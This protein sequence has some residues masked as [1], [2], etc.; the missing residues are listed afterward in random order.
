MDT[1]FTNVTIDNLE[2]DVSYELVVKSGNSE[3]TSHLTPSVTFVTADK[4]I[5]K[6]SPHY[7]KLDNIFSPK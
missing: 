6:T 1:P 4:Y 5:V 2:P 3:G 7:G